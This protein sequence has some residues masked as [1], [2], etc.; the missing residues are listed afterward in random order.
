MTASLASRTAGRSPTSRTNK[1]S[2]TT[3]SNPAPRR[4][5]A[6]VLEHLPC[7]RGRI[8]RPD[9]LA[10]NVLRDLAADHDQS[11]AAGHDLAVA[12]PGGAAPAGRHPPKPRPGAPAR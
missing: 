12:P 8:S 6:E 2:L 10:V 7:L 1:V 4:A 3:V 11:A 5:A 9:Q